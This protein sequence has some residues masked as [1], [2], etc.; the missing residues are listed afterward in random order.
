LRSVATGVWYTVAAT[1]IALAVAVVASSLAGPAEREDV[2][3]GTGAGLLLQVV[4]FWVLAVWLFPT[5]RL[6]MMGLG[7][8]V[9]MAALLAAVLAAPRMGYELAPTLLTMVTVFVLTTLLE[10]VLFQLETKRAI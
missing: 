10:P 5:K 6:L 4:S 8:L 3:A 1:A 2:F 7:M 9:R